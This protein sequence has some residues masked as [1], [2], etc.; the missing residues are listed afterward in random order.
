MAQYELEL[1]QQGSEILKTPMEH[2]HEYPDYAKRYNHFLEQY[3]EIGKSKLADY[4]VHRKIIIEF[5]EKILQKRDDD[6]YFL[7]RDVH[8]IIYPMQTTSD[9]IDYIQHNLWIID[10][11][12]SYHSILASDKKLSDLEDSDISSD[13]RPDILI[14]NNPIAFIEDANQPYSSIVIIEFKRPM[15]KG[16]SEDENPFTQVYGYVRKIKSG[17]FTDKNGLLVNLRPN[18]PFYIYI[19]CDLTPNLKKFAEDNSFKETPDGQGYYAFNPNFNAYV[20]V[21]SF[22]KLLSDARK[23]N[24]ILFDTLNI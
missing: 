15:R 23:R 7:E 2:F 11:R 5:L 24:K 4:V 22:P 1:K 19:I 3:N 13:K 18:T 21:I 8:E 9:D 12:L 10:E 16:Y 14:F 20:E 6:R 17:K